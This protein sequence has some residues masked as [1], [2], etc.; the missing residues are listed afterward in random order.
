VSVTTLKPYLWAK[1]VEKDEKG[2]PK[3]TTYIRLSGEV[4]LDIPFTYNEDTRIYEC[5]FQVPVSDS[6]DVVAKPSSTGETMSYSNLDF[7]KE[8][9]SPNVMING[10]NGKASM[11]N[12]FVSGTIQGSGNFTEAG[13]GSANI[14]KMHSGGAYSGGTW[15][16]IENGRLDISRYS[17]VRVVEWSSNPSA[18]GVKVLGYLYVD[19]SGTIKVSSVA[20][21]FYNPNKGRIPST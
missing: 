21:D 7:Y 20:Q 15:I 6:Y 2:V 11:N 9:F 13:I 3:D 10:L 8:W 16:D 12:V 19:S 14:R 4:L 17:K 5:L 18:T 1:A